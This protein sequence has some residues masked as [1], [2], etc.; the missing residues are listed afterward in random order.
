MDS[1][2]KIYRQIPVP[3]TT[4]ET[5]T[6]FHFSPMS[7]ILIC[8]ISHQFSDFHSSV[9]YKECSFI[10]GRLVEEDK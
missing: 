7:Q 3:D 9:W 6:T 4:P 2:H 8:M 1:K 5:V 10:L